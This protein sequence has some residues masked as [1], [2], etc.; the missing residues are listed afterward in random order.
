MSVKHL[1]TVTAKRDAMT[2]VKGMKVEIV[3][4]NRSGKPSIKEIARA[5][6]EKYGIK[7]LGSSGL[8]E[9]TF[10]FDQG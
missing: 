1:W 9:S 8:P 4:E 2:V 10:D 7:D 5:L 6:S 3:V